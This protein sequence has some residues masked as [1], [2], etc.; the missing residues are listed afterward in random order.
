[1]F[2]LTNTGKKKTLP[3]RD[4]RGCHCNHLRIN[5]EPKNAIRQFIKNLNARESHYSRE[6][7]PHKYFLPSGTTISQLYRQILA[8]HPEYQ[9]NENNNRNRTFYWLFRKI[10]NT[11]FNIGVGYPRS[12]LCNACELFSTEIK[13]TTREGPEARYH[14]LKQ[15][16]LNH[17]DSASQFY[18]EIQSCTQ[19]GDEYLV[20]CCAFEKNLS[21]SITGINCEYFSSNLNAYNFGVKNMQTGEAKM[22][23]KNIFQRSC[24]DFSVVY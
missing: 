4:G 16:Q 23:C 12:D 14:E 8:E 1:M 5:L 21:L 22:R 15:S 17:W 2:L 20:L 7:N 13:V 24:I 10:F 3:I 18:A 6:S 19:L 11:E 9:P